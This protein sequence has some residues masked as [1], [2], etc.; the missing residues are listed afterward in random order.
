MI[1]IIKSENELLYKLNEELN[2]KI[3]SLE[4]KCTQLEEQNK[5]L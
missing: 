3:G 4:F 1:K 2:T 5:F